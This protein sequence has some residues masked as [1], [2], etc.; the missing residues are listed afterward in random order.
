MTNIYEY[1]FNVPANTPAET[2]ED[3]F[4]EVFPGCD[5]PGGG[6]MPASNIEAGKCLVLVRTAW[7]VATMEQMASDAGKNWQIWGCRT[8]S[9]DIPAVWDHTDPENPELVSEAEHEYV[10]PLNNSVLNLL[11]QKYYKDEDGNPT[12]PIPKSASHIPLFVGSNPW[13]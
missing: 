6:V 5:I 4:K 2:I 10:V 7:D 1:I 9:K 3:E 12:T 8:V 13:K 11:T